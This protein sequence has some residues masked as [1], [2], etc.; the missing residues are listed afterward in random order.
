[1]AQWP[2]LEETLEKTRFKYGLFQLK[3]DAISFKLVRYTEFKKDSQSSLFHPT[4]RIVA[5]RDVDKRT[6]VRK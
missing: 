4:S 3:C 2:A 5:I 1:L 6:F